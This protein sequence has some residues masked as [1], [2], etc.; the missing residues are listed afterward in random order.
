[1]DAMVKVLLAAG[2]C[3]NVRAAAAVRDGDEMTN[4]AH[5]IGG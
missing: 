2:L 5:R 3:E 4:L 1:M